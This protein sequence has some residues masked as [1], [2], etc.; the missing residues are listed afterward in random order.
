VQAYAP[1]ER[2]L[3]FGETADRIFAL[4]RGSV[5]VFTQN[6]AGGEVLLVIFGAPALFGHAEALTKVP[7]L[8]NVEASEPCE[9]V[10]MPPGALLDFFRRDAGCATAMIVDQAVNLTFTIQH[11]R[12]LAFD[13]A[14]TRLANFLVDYALWTHQVGN[15][16]LV[17]LTLD[18]MAGAIAASRRSV[19]HDFQMWSKEGILERKGRHY[20]VRDMEALRRYC[21]PQHLSLMY[22]VGGVV[23]PLHA[24]PTPS[25]SG[26]GGPRK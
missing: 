9:L 21:D 17:R 15:D 26:R 2:I 20:V 25:G 10:I 4:E 8:E 1:G 18:E 3:S 7:Y 23:Q 19:A 16:L 6:P 22:R 13:S 12:S 5:R 14:T 24:R 11:E